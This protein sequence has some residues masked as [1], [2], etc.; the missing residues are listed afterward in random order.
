MGSSDAK[1]TI[2]DDI[3]APQKDSPFFQRLP[4]DIRLKIYEEVLHYR[5]S[6]FCYGT[7]CDH[8]LA[9]R[10]MYLNQNRDML[11]TCRAIH[12]EAEQ[13]LLKWHYY[14]IL[15]EPRHQQV[16]RLNDQRFMN[17]IQNLIIDTY[18]LSDVDGIGGIA[19]LVR[20][21]CSLKMVKKHCVV[22][23]EDWTLNFVFPDE[24]DGTALLRQLSR[25]TLF[26][27][28]HLAMHRAVRR[29]DQPHVLDTFRS[30]LTPTL[31]PLNDLL[32]INRAVPRWRVIHWEFKPVEFQ[33][34]L[35][36]ESLEYL[37]VLFGEEDAA[38]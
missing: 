21:L 28:A 12:V 23:L 10:S 2:S 5:K 33:K 27:T 29:D 8:S 25:L 30:T 34:R 1:T 15:V 19:D 17:R 4:L 20:K 38:D 7:V 31:G 13:I 37:R 24:R 6:R 22:H 9:R 35:E 18:Y 14:D 3:Y 32:R 16:S 36:Q 26:T 11:R